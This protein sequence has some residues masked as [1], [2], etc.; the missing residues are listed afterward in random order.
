M[1]TFGFCHRRVSVEAL[2]PL[3]RASQFYCRALL[4]RSLIEN[5]EVTRL[6]GLEAV[7]QTQRAI[8]T[9]LEAL[10]VATKVRELHGSRFHYFVHIIVI[11]HKCIASNPRPGFTGGF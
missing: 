5:D 8:A 2:S 10:A 6:S 11:N 7:H 4:A 3:F 1:C 9:V